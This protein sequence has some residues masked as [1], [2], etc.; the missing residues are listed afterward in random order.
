MYSLV[1][2]RWFFLFL[3]KI[4][5]CFQFLKSVLFR[6]KLVIGQQNA[7]FLLLIF[8]SVV[9]LIFL[10]FSYLALIPQLSIGCELE[11]LVKHCEKPGHYN[12]RGKSLIA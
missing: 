12:S 8:K 9:K 7:N 11:R 5:R 1:N 6:P 4:L 10:V 2:R 3:A